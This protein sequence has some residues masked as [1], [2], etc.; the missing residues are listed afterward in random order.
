MALYDWLV[1]EG[2]TDRSQPLW[3]LSLLII[4][5]SCCNALAKKTFNRALS[6]SGND[7]LPLNSS[8][9]SA[10]YY[11]HPV[12]SSI[13]PPRDGTGWRNLHG[14]DF[15]VSR[16]FNDPRRELKRREKPAVGVDS[17]VGDLTWSFFLEETARRPASSQR[18]GLTAKRLS[19][20][21]RTGT[22][23]GTEPARQ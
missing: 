3:V 23:G 10:P 7:T 14:S 9:T 5:K 12:S 13:R 17:G 18:G 16:S 21:S 22:R 19:V 15:T 11:R 8:S 1:S 4:G 6:Q 20:Q 2:A